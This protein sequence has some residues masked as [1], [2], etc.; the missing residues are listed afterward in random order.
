MARGTAD[1]NIN[2]GV[3][4]QTSH[5][6]DTAEKFTTTSNGT[7][8]GNTKLTVDPFFT[9]PSTQRLHLSFFQ[10][11]LSHSFI[12]RFGILINSVLQEWFQFDITGNVSP[13][14]IGCLFLPSGTAFGFDITNELNPTI[15]YCVTLT[16][17]REL[18]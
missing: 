15:N 6:A 16:G 11:T 14:D 7:I 1:Y 9:V 5:I 2:I 8:A 12:A 13:A 4:P 17:V 3:A 10:A 18:E